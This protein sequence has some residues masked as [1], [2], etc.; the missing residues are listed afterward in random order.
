MKTPDGI[1]NWLVQHNCGEWCS[2][3]VRQDFEGR[4]E[5]IIPSCSG[6]WHKIEWLSMNGWKNWKRQAS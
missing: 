6:R 1:G 3:E 5:A 4:F 2:A